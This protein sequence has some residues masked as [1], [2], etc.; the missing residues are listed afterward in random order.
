MGGF[1]IS[2]VILPLLIAASGIIMSIVGTILVVVKEGGNPQKALNKGEFI[3]SFILIGV[4]Y[5]LIQNILPMNFALMAYPTRI[6]VYLSL[7]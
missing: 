1:D 2:F 6:L 5:F 4:I 7:P 3:S